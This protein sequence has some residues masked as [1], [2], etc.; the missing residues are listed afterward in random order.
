M[1]V[2]ILDFWQGEQDFAHKPTSWDILGQTN[3]DEINLLDA[4]TPGWDNHV[5]DRKACDVVEEELEDKENQLKYHTEFLQN[6]EDEQL[7]KEMGLI[8]FPAQMNRQF[9]T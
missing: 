4:L 3:L 1:W 8:S 6:S 5:A 7:L 2:E 9:G